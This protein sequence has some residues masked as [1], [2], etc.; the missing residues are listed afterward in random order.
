MLVEQQ[1]NLNPT[2][3]SRRYEFFVALLLVKFKLAN[4]NPLSLVLISTYAFLQH[5]LFGYV[6]TSGAQYSPYETLLGS[7]LL[8][9]TH[10]I[11]TLLSIMYTHLVAVLHFIY[12]NL[13]ICCIFIYYQC[14]QKTENLRLVLFRLISF[15]LQ[16]REGG[17]YGNHS[18][19]TK[20]KPTFQ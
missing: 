2:R 4:M 18:Q 19:Q 20:S 13:I 6:K 11:F 12:P 3:W 14:S 10:L 5:T 17:K 8:Y 7:Q 16:K 15:Y 1:F 9:S